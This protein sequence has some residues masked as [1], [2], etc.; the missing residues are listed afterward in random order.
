[1]SMNASTPTARVSVRCAFATVATGLLWLGGCASTATQLGA[2]YVDP[3]LP[4]QPLRG[5]A[6]LVVCEATEPAL[7][8][9]CES[10]VSAQLVLLGARPLTDATLVNPTPGREP[11]AGQYLP[12]AQAAGARAVFSTTLAPD[13]SIPSAV[14]SFSIGIGGFGGSGGGYRGGSSVG[15]GVGVTLPV[16]GAPPA[17]SGLAAIGSIVDAGNGRVMWT[18]KAVTPP[19]ADL[20]GQIAEA[21]KALVASAQQAGLF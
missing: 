16:G 12:A 18:T 6:I 9:I 3:Q 14:P 17:T 1:M 2:Q 20:N 10:Q 15:G 5:A 21:A 19:S 8:L 11:P 13:F 4:K 7:K